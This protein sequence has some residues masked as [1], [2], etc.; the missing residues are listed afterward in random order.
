MTCVYVNVNLT[1]WVANDRVA[2]KGGSGTVEWAID[3]RGRLP[4]RDFFG[5]LDAGDQAKVL[6]LFK[7]LAENWRFY[8][9]DKFK[10]LGERGGNLYEFKSFQIRFL[11]DFRSGY[12]FL[13][14]HG[15]KKKRDTLSPG[16]V[17]VAQR[18]LLENDEREGG[19]P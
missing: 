6:A 18:V 8:N 12:R 7:R 14:A 3:A 5:G 13:V 17:G 16:D 9:R 11:G 1:S 19:Q 10:S 2:A 4:A 15:V